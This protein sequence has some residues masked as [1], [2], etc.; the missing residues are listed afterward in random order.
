MKAGEKVKFTADSTEAT[1]LKFVLSIQNG[2]ED[3]QGKVAEALIE[4]AAKHGNKSEIGAL[5]NQILD[6]QM[7]AARN[8]DARPGKNQKWRA[9]KAAEMA[10][11]VVSQTCASNPASTVEVISSDSDGNFDFLESLLREYS[12]IVDLL[13]W[14][15]ATACHATSIS[16]LDELLNKIAPAHPL[17]DRVKRQRD[18]SQKK[19]D[20]GKLRWDM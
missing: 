8:G 15:R 18:W 1:D 20:Q 4:L 5:A 11:V 12:R 13:I 17:Y 3:C 7:E 9:Q 6:E 14:L 19:L 16:Y 10:Q 2:T